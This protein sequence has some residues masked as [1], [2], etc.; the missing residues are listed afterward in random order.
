[1]EKRKNLTPERATW[2]TRQAMVHHGLAM[3]LPW[4]AFVNVSFALMI[5]LRHVLLENSVFLY[6]G[7]QHL[8]RVVDASMLGIIIL[9]AAL[10]LMAWRRIAGI[11]VVLF[12]CSAFW[13]MCSYWFITALHLP[14]VWP[15]CVILLLSGLTAL[16]FYPEG[17]L[18]FVLPLWLTLPVASWVLND[19]L[20]LRFVTIWSVFTLI[21]LCGRFILLS[22]FDEAWRRNQQNQLLI[23]RLDALAHQD[24][25]TKTANRRMMEVVLENAVEQNKAFSLIMLDIDYFKLYNDT[26]GHQAGDDCLTRVAQVLKQAVRTPDDVVSRYGGEEFVVILFNCPENVAQQVARRIQDGLRAAAI[27]HGASKVSEHVTV[28]MG[29]AGIAPGLAGPE[30]IA[31]ADA[32]LYRAKEAGRDRWSL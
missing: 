27:P 2:P 6:P 8:T 11:S 31:R 16:Y 3:N 1:M 4:L 10:I 17:L 23:S 32:A 30:L 24:P 14:H 5:L 7:S 29:I 20:N 25:L 18:S 9:S 21:M 28:S 13:S 15:L 26:Y 12:V 19:G 22:W